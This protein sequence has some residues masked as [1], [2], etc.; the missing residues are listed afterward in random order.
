MI[1]GFFSLLIVII[2]EFPCMEI[3][4]LHLVLFQKKKNSDE[5][6][7]LNPYPTKW[8]ERKHMFFFRVLHHIDLS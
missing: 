1:A 8:F 2:S 5:E 4:R 7:E 6:E 3:K